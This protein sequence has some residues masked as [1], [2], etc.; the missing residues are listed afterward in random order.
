MTNQPESSFLQA[1]SW[2]VRSSLSED[3]DETCDTLSLVCRRC[4]KLHTLVLALELTSP[5][6]EHLLTFAST[7]V[8][9]DALERGAPAL[10]T[11]QLVVR[12]RDFDGR[13]FNLAMLWDALGWLG[14]LSALTLCWVFVN[15]ETDTHAGE[16]V[17]ALLDEVCLVSNACLLGVSDLCLAT[18]GTVLE[19]EGP[20]HHQVVTRMRCNPSNRQ[21]NSKDA[22]LSNRLCLV[23]HTSCALILLT[24]TCV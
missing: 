2:L 16:V 20:R 15:D 8:S 10:V 21:C 17:A 1:S 19:L 3:G 24:W 4:P 22:S 6:A 23:V 11:L 9:L 18:T 12:V 14:R 7:V 5:S 13:G